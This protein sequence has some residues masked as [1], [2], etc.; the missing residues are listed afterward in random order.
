MLYW[1]LHH[2][3][4]A[5]APVPPQCIWPHCT[6]RPSATS[7]VAPALQTNDLSLHVRT[8]MPTYHPPPG[9]A[10]P[11]SGAATA[12]AAAAGAP[13]SSAMVTSERYHA[14]VD[15]AG[16]LTG[17]SFLACL[18]L[19]NVA[20]TV[21]VALG[22]PAGGASVNSLSGGD[23][24]IFEAFSKAAEGSV[25]RDEVLTRLE[26]VD[27]ADAKGGARALLSLEAKLVATTMEDFGLSKILGEVIEIVVLCR[28]A[29]AAGKL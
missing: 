27:F 28:K 12:T 8:H 1:H 6:Y 25:K 2:Q 3:H 9:Y 18:V 21:K 5:T 24:S 17:L 26:K 13:E 11:P 29:E 7:T 15:E 10:Y 23:E 19:R 16:E 4:L 14:K 20:R 22:N